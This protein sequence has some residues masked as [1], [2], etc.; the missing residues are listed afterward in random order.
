M[1]TSRDIIQQG[2]ASFGTSGVRALVSDL[3]DRLC[4]AYCAGFLEVIGGCSAVILGMDL[5]PSSPR[6]AAACTAAVQAAG[7]EV[8]WCGALPT[9][10]LASFAIAAGMPSIMVTGS[11]IPFDRNGIKFYRAEG[12]ISK[13]DELAIVNAPAPMSGVAAALTLPSADPSA[14]TAY[15]NR[16]VAFFGTDA[17]RGMRIGFWQHSSVAWDQL[18]QILESL[19]AKV[20]PLGRTDQFVPIDTESVAAADVERAKAWARDSGFDALISTDGDADRPLIGDQEGTWFRGDVVG[21]LTARYLGIRHIVTPVTSTTALERSNLFETITRTKVG[22]PYVLEALDTH[23]RKGTSGGVAGFEANGGFLLSTALEKHGRSLAP[24]PTRDAA[25][26]IITL[27]AASRA[28]GQPMSKL[29]DGL[30]ARFTA[31]D[32]LT[33][34]SRENSKAL[35]E[36]L[37][38]PGAALK[39]LD[40]RCGNLTSTD[41]TDG[42][43]MTF[44]GLSPTNSVIV[45]LRPSGNAPELRCYVEAHDAATAGEL[46]AF[47]LSRV[48]P[49]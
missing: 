33:N 25:L 11:H 22:S 12:E 39:L 45:H 36:G 43:R 24:L 29:Q 19:G 20:T 7:R 23:L 16:Y 9:P 44:A 14:A 8:I 13:A 18:T 17:L 28:A 48:K 41:Q 31:S 5:R 15:A 47:V 26:P 38:Q 2:A 6:I 40:Q 46:V 42:L 49:A 32:R 1:T 30:P 3:D 35:L 37:L 4:M 27:L 10:A 34:F 21:L